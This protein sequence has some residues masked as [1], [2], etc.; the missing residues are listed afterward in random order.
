MHDLAEA[1]TDEEE[2]EEVAELSFSFTVGR[3]A[4]RLLLPSQEVQAE[5]REAQ[6]P[7]TML[8]QEAQAQLLQDLLVT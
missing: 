3:Q 8:V 4:A 6:E 7:Q 1:E 2:V 5:H